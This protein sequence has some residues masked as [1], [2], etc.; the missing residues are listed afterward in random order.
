MDFA[1]RKYRPGYYVHLS[2]KKAISRQSIAISR[3]KEL[4]KRIAGIV[5]IPPKKET[6]I[7]NSQVS[8]Y[9][10]ISYQPLAISQKQNVPIYIG[11]ENEEIENNSPSKENA[12][13]LLDKIPEPSLLYYLVWFLMLCIILLFLYFLGWFLLLLIHHYGIILGILAFIGIFILFIFVKAKL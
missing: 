5:P 2:S 13:D 9:K 12:K 8:S 1:K 10:A 6:S 7:P 4:D 11:I 3:T